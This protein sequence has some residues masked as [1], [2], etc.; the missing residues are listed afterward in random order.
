ME[1]DREHL[2]MFPLFVFRILNLSPPPMCGLWWGYGG[3]MIKTASYGVQI[4][5]LEKREVMK[6]HTTSVPTAGR[7]WEN[8]MTNYKTLEKLFPKRKHESFHV[9]EYGQWIEIGNNQPLSCDTL[10]GC[11]RCQTGRRLKSELTCF[12]PNCGA[13]MGGEPNG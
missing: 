11:S 6:G 1:Q 8:K 5:D 7:R 9:V 13:K 10:Y 4:A 12:C 2:L 3:S